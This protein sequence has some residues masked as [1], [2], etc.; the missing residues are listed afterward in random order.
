MGMTQV[1]TECI[2]TASDKTL[3]GIQCMT[4]GRKKS[5]GGVRPFFIHCR[6]TNG[7]VVVKKVKLRT[8]LLQELASHVRSHSVT[9]HPAEVTLPPFPLLST[10]HVM[11]CDYYSH[12][13]FGYLYPTINKCTG[14]NAITLV[15]RSLCPSVS[16]LSFEP[17]DLLH[18]CESL[19][20]LAGD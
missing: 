11:L 12:R 10:V 18:A 1:F 4:R 9:C 5:L 6:I 17:T 14:N 20:W 3:T 16:T 8:S 19:P 2:L 15:R 7:R 13:C